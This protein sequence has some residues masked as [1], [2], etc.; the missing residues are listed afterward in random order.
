[1]EIKS[2]SKMKIQDEVPRWRSNMEVQYGDSI[3]MI[4]IKI[5]D[6]VPR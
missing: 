3:W 5:Q 6:G 2:V 1:M 4:K